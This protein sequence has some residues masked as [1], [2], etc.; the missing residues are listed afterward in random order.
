MLQSALDRPKSRRK[1]GKK[2]KAPNKEPR[3]EVESIASGQK[4]LALSLDRNA[5]NGK[6]PGVH[7][8]RGGG[9]VTEGDLGI[10]EGIGETYER[11]N[12]NVRS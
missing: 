10:G 2:G 11:R 8:E 4:N 1:F 7:I 9:I 12:L 3:L 5:I 6:K